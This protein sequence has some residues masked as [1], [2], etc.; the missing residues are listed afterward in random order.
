MYGVL[1]LYVRV[2]RHSSFNSLL[3]RATVLNANRGLF[4]YTGST[5]T[6]P[7]PL[8]SLAGGSTRA[9]QSSS[10]FEHTAIIS[11]WTKNR[12]MDQEDI[13][14]KMSALRR[15]EAAEYKCIDYFKLMSGNDETKDPVCISGNVCSPSCPSDASCRR[16]MFHWMVQV[17]DFFPDMKR[18]T[19]AFA[20]DYLDRFLQTQTKDASQARINRKIF[21]LAAMT[22]F[23]TAVKIHEEA[24]I[25]PKFLEDLSQK[26]YSV[27]DVETM[28]V[29]ILNAL[30]WRLNTPTA[31]TFLRLYLDLIPPTMLKKSTRAKAAA[32]AQIQVEASVGEYRYVTGNN[33]SI[34]FGALMNA[35][36]DLQVESL[37]ISW[38]VSEATSIDC[39]CPYIQEIKQFLWQDAGLEDSAISPIAA[40]STVVDS[41]LV[42][43][44]M[45]A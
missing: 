40:D 15:Q 17:T 10:K 33:S 16:A 22:C 5:R 4:H 38:L 39:N 11:N 44:S 43:C 36:S 32:I 26:A 30:Q 21:Q 28:E 20:V 41:S 2:P 1:L 18:E 31:M 37:S 42:I 6:E 34:A 24:A 12:T 7:R 13:L 9:W 25:S 27:Q 8:F 19:V 14:L 35:L 45:A 29:R 23:Y 3:A